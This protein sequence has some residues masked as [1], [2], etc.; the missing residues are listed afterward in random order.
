MMDLIDWI[1][2]IATAVLVYA[3]LRHPLYPPRLGKEKD[4]AGRDDAGR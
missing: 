2:A 3:A 1:T 4:A